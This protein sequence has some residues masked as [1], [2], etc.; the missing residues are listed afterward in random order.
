MLNTKPAE[1]FSQCNRVDLD[2]GFYQEGKGGFSKKCQKFCRPFFWSTRF[3]LHQSII[4][5]L[6]A[7]F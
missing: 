5:T 6:Q 3:E 4:K 7:N 2:P 1:N